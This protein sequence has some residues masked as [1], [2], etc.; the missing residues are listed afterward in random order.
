MPAESKDFPHPAGSDASAAGAP[1]ALDAAPSPELLGALGRLV[2][3]LSVLFWALPISL[4]VCVQCAKGDW[5]R[6]LGV[7]PPVL[8]TGLLYYGLNLC[9][10]FQMQERVWSAALGRVKLVALF[11][12]GLSPFLY[13]WSR[14]PSQPFF[15]AVA[16]VLMISGILFL[17]ALNPMLV[18]LTSMLPDETLRLETRFFA[19]LNRGILVGTLVA[20]GGYFGLIHIDPALP[21]RLLGLVLQVSRLPAQANALLYVFERAGPWVFLF[22]VLLPLAMTMA[23]V[24]KIKEVILASVFGPE[25][26]AADGR[27]I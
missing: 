22:F 11:N 8:A 20:V 5:F 16:Q 17:I 4:V 21:D 6:Q 13:W 19:T 25:R 3:G 23:L 27:R 2:R 9:G 15:A 7:I 24:W 12:L 14:I 26:M 1:S 18:R 10:H